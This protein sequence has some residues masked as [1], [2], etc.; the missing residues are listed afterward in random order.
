MKLILSLVEDSVSEFLNTIKQKASALKQKTSN[1]PKPAT[2]LSGNGADPELGKYKYL[3][4]A[5]FE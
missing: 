4:G 5:T 3:D 1:A 2:N